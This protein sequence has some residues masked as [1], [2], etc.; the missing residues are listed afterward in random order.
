VEKITR[1]LKNNEKIKMVSMEK[2]TTKTKSFPGNNQKERK[3]LMNQKI[4]E[5]LKVAKIW[6]QVSGKGV[7]VGIFDTGIVKDHKAF[8]NIVESINFSNEDSTED[9][10]GH[11]IF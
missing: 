1:I 8:K 7:N 2:R 9:K 3:L 4:I 6:N 11:G 5:K 10:V